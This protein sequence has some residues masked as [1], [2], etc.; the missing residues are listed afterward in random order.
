MPISFTVK[1][2]Y[3]INYRGKNYASLTTPI[4]SYTCSVCR[5]AYCFT[6]RKHF[7]TI[8]QVVKQFVTSQETPTPMGYSVPNHFPM[9]TNDYIRFV[10]DA[11][12]LCVSR[13]AIIYSHHWLKRMTFIP[14]RPNSFVDE[15]IS[16][17]KSVATYVVG[18]FCCLEMDGNLW[19][20]SFETE[21]ICL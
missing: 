14:W 20:W 1:A 2:T 7:L 8:T 21:F 4:V 10:K 19:N 18:S 9:H 6:F 15:Y 13:V 5:R 12:T 3:S 17:S 11:N 16:R